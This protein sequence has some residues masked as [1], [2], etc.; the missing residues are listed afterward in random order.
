MDRS[1]I[2]AAGKPL[3][4][5]G[6]VEK[7]VRVA[8]LAMLGAAF[9][10][11]AARAVDPGNACDNTQV[12]SCQNIT[13][14]GTLGRL[15]STGWALYCPSDAPYWWQD[16]STDSSRTTSFTVNAVESTGNKADFLITNWSVL[17]SSDWAIS[18]DC[19]PISPTGNCS[20][21]QT[22]SVKDP[23]CP[24]SNQMTVCDGGDN[25]W[26]EWDETCVNGNAVS[27]YFCS[28]VLFVTTCWG[29]GD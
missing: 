24:I 14:S 29:C 22:K 25:C 6:V 1:R 7:T 4:L 17:G 5:A 18:I 10:A 3:G 2:V 13:A 15:G 12:P 9:C 26:L 19:S 20:S 28:Q 11:G 23:G 21:P 8:V 27:N 16:Y